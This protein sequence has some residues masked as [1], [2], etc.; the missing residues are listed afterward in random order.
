MPK[1]SYKVQ[2]IED[3]EMVGTIDGSSEDEVLDLLAERN[4]IPISIAELN[5]D[6]SKKDAT[7]SENRPLC[8][9]FRW[10]F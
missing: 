4:L 6:G 10:F 2:D 5:F 9:R 1:F 7:F 8:F 3:R